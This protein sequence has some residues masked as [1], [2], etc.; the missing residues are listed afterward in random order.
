MSFT[1]ELVLGR[2]ERALERVVSLCGR[3]GYELVAVNASTRPDGKFSVRLT[4]ASDRNA[5]T[6]QRQL[7][8]L[9]EVEAVQL[10]G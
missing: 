9:V 1:L 2:A 5:E 7:E 4:L 10:V 8:K 3:R 6:L